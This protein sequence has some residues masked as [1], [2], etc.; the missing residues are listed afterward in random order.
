[1][2][3][4]QNLLAEYVRDGSETAFRELVSCYLDLVYST[5]RRSVNGDVHLAQDVAQIVFTDFARMA[6]KLTGD[7]MLGGWLHRHT[8]FVASTL[9]RGRR[10]REAREKLAVEMNLQT[11]HTEANLA[12]VRA[13][14]DEG[15]DQLG[16]ADRAAIL[17]RFFEQREFGAIGEALGTNEE[18]A[19]KRVNRAV[20]RLHGVL[21]QRGVAFSVTALGTMLAAEAVSAAP[22]GLA[23][24]IAG[25]AL[26]GAAMGTG[27]TLTVLK[28][29]TM[30]KL[31]LSLFGALL[32]AGVAVPLVL[33]PQLWVREEKHQ[34]AAFR[35]TKNR[36]AMEISGPAAPAL[37]ESQLHELL[38]LRGEVTRLREDS[39]EL[40][41]LK[42]DASQ[43]EMTSWLSQVD[44]LRKRLEQNHE[45]EIP[46]F[47]FLTEQDW[48][49]CVGKGNILDTDADYR[50][51]LSRLRDVAKR[52]FMP[53]AMSALNQY[54][55]ANGHQLP[56]EPS[57]L[58]PYFDPPIDP[59][60]LNRY[61]ILR[62]GKVADLPSP[63]EKLMGE[64]GAVDD[65]FDS[66][67]E[68]AL[69]GYGNSGVGFAGSPQT[70]D[71]YLDAVKAFKS[72]HDGHGPSTPSDL[73]A[74]LK[75]PVPESWLQQLFK[76][77]AADTR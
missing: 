38:R 18:A 4:T 73:Q 61:K 69:D 50:L 24:G 19:R 39:R 15:I 57:Q 65:L 64:K 40:A 16:S 31:K 11:D 36:V 45:G 34:M 74:Y 21:K 75:Q 63:D 29:M 10:R 8:C 68:V 30:S 53:M 54:A 60:V 27:T 58:Q 23:A 20:E 71:N 7:A 59:A 14:L 76:P 51:A 12:R 46:E 41:G 56:T 17:L 66:Y 32:L 52:K 6:R 13:V 1:M 47:Q 37:P 42:A 28:L 49:D 55:A 44:R 72:A 62:S 2:T 25:S 33:L 3:E 77:D 67:Y 70:L 5:A 35:A 26:A 9:M 43:A 22:V 48:Y